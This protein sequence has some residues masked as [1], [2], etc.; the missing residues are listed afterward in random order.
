MPFTTQAD[1]KPIVTSARK[2]GKARR[3]GAGKLPGIITLAGWRVRE[4]WRML[5]ITGLGSIIA[6][7]L[8][9]AV[10]LYSDVSMSAGLR[11]VISTSYQSSD[12]V[13]QAQSNVISSAFISKA[14]RELNEEFQKKLGAYLKPLEFSVLTSS[15]YLLVSQPTSCSGEARK[16]PYFSCDLIRF[17]SAP[18]QQTETGAHLRLVQGRLPGNSSDGKSLEVALTEESARNLHVTIGSLLHTTFSASQ[19]PVKDVVIPVVLRVVGIFTPPA[20]NDPF[21]HG[22]TYV[23][24]PRS[25]AS[26]NC[27]YRAD[28]ERGHRFAV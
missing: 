13:V 17:I 3:R 12:I 27:L 4:T 16:P 6:V 9:C 14:T 22:N 2:A 19:P 15:S 26:W 1:E 8:V 7:M 11:G 5:L 24:V 23:S 28:F 25:P 18:V 10:P 20:G 21:W